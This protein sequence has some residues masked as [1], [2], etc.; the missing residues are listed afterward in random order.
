MPQT[1]LEL[2]RGLY[3]AF[4]RGDAAAVLATMDPQVVWNEAENFPYAEGNPYAGPGAIAQ[5]VFLRLA[6]EW[7]GFAASPHTFH[8]AGDT[9]VVEGRYTGRFKQT[10]REL[11]AQFAHIYWLREGRVVRFQQYTDTAQAVRVTG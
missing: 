6:T 2:I 5:G 8:D 11:N 10:G 7:E 4:A 9:V 3:Q 1:N